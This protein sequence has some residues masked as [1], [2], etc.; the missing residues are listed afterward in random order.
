ML[1]RDYRKVHRRILIVV[2]LL[3]L[4]LTAIGG[5]AFSLQV[6]Q[7]ERHAGMAQRQTAGSVVIQPRRGKIFDRRQRILASNQ[8]VPSLMAQP[9]NMS[10]EEISTAKQL[11]KRVLDLPDSVLARLDSKRY[12]VWLARRLDASDETRVN[13]ALAELPEEK[14][15]SGLSFVKEDKRLYAFGQLASPILGFTNMDM[16]GRMGL[17]MRFNDDLRG[18][19]R[20]LQGLRDP[21][22]KVTWEHLDL[23]LDVPTGDHLYL[24]LDKNIQYV[25]EREI[26]KAVKSSKARVGIAIA[27][28]PRS[29]GILAMAQYPTFDPNNLNGVK[30]SR[31]HNAAVEWVYEPGSTLK[32]FIVAQALETAQLVPDDKIYCGFGE[33]TIG[34]NTI[35][36]TKRHG[37]LSVNEVIAKSSNI[38]AAKIGTDLGADSVYAILRDF[39]FGEKSGIRLPA[40][41]AGLLAKPEDWEPIELA[42]ISFGQG[43]NVTAI[44][45]VTAM[46]AIANG[47]K[48]MRPRVVDR[49]TTA[50]GVEKK[51][52]E[53]SVVRQVISERT[54]RQLIDMLA[55]AASTEGTGRK[56][57][58]EGC[59]VAGK[60]GTSEKL[61]MNARAGE[62]IYW[63]GS[64]LGLFPAQDPRVVLLVMVD[65]PRGDEYYGGDIAAPAFHNI[66]KEIA[67]ILGVCVQQANLL[68]EP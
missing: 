30:P 50:D 49:V 37:W 58:I 55:M 44:Q 19:E 39:G 61:A 25:A 13:E 38:G 3:F 27:M 6:L 29:G 1:D 45:L 57:L 43:L 14:R 53:P 34:P 47:G 28:D 23:T 17:E 33:F 40:E 42:T 12:F 67:P 62:R 20:T 35:H 63:T 60:T 64:F 54:S 66:A 48:L 16:K 65:E 22:G 32:P 26:E 59:Q 4:G 36:D 9:R 15:P 11:L 31:L 52:F 21:S 56:A 5:Q 18:S 7:G 68:E 8:Q 10:P 41:S 2:G 46:S 24:T 51:V